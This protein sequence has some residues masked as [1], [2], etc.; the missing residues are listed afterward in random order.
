MDLKQDEQAYSPTERDALLNE[1]I[2]LLQQ[3]ISQNRL[4]LKKLSKDKAADVD[5]YFPIIREIEY[6]ISKTDATIKKYFEKNDSFLDVDQLS[7]IQSLAN[8]NMQVLEELKYKM[9]DQLKYFAQSLK[10]ARTSN[11]MIKA[12]PMKNKQNSTVEFNV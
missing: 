8:E 9:Q 5:D 2:Q 1:Q 3:L 4:V 12:M 6:K 7:L 11:K 10:H